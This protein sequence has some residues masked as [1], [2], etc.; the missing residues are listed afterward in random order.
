MDKLIREG[1]LVRDILRDIM[2]LYKLLDWLMWI[3][4]IIALLVVV[5]K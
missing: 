2:K 3:V 1:R 5:M 4:I